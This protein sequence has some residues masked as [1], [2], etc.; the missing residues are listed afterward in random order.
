M[1]DQTTINE[2]TDVEKPDDE[3]LGLSALLGCLPEL[4]DAE[5]AAMNS[6]PGDAV[7]HWWN[8]ERWN[9][10][11]W[12]PAEPTK[13]SDTERLKFLA[14]CGSDDGPVIESFVNVFDEFNDYLGQVLAE[15]LP[16]GDDVPD[17]LEATDGD[18]VEAFRRLIDAAIDGT[19]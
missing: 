16:E 14:G 5:R 4:N 2:A 6:F 18:Q 1:S 3:P 7:E 13:R 17:D 8:G 12:R 11:A 10:S 9:G 15:R 19:G